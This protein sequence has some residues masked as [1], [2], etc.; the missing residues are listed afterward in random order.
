M[1]RDVWL[2]KARSFE[3]LIGKYREQGEAEVFEP[4]AKGWLGMS[5]AEERAQ[6]GAG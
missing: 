1:E 3:P 6:H 2:G 5:P 4:V